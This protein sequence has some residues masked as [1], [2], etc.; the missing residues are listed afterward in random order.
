MS[1]DGGGEPSG[2]LADAINDTFGS[3]RRA[4]GARSNDAGVKR[5]GSG[6]TWLVHDGTGLAVD[7]T[8]NQ[9]SPIMR[10]PTTPLLGHRRLGARVLPQVPE[11]P[12]RLPRGVVERRQLGRRV[13]ER[14]AKA[15][16]KRR[17]RN[18]VGRELGRR[19]DPTCRRP[20]GP[21][22]YR[23]RKLRLGLA[24]W[25]RPGTRVAGRDEDP[26]CG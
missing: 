20:S 6:W 11:P 21:S 13:A 8:P 9:D 7:S 5:F 26:Q 10:R 18:D 16:G 19:R 2:A 17:G 22:P 3:R 12:P 15:I 24:P 1:P 4:E 14:Y 25:K 23:R